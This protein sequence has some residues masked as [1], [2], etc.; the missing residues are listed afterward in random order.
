MKTGPL[1]LFLQWIRPSDIGNLIVVIFGLFLWVSAPVAL[2]RLCLQAIFE[3]R[4]KRASIVTSRAPERRVPLLAQLLDL[5][6]GLLF[7]AA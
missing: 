2:F 5:T 1:A 6:P 7:S 3:T 4:P